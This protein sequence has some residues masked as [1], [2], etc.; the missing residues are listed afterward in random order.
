M[1]RPAL[2]AQVPVVRYDGLEIFGHILKHY[3]LEPIKSIDD[4]GKYPPEETVIVVFGDLTPLNAIKQA[5]PEVNDYV[6]L[7]ATDR[8]T[9]SFDVLPEIDFNIGWMPRSGVRVAGRK[10]LQE[11]QNAFKELT[12]CPMIRKETWEWDRKNV[13]HPLFARVNAIAT[14]RPSY[15]VNYRFDLRRL[16]PYPSDC[17]SEGLRLSPKLAN[18]GYVF[19]TEGIKPRTLLLAGHG[20]FMNGMLVAPECD[21]GLFAVN[22]VRWLREDPAGNRKYVL[23]LH[24][25]KVIDRLGLPLTGMPQIP[26]KLVNKL[27]RDLEDEGVF[28]RALENAVDGWSILRFAI[29]AGTALLVMYG[30]YRLFL[31]RHAQESVPL[32]VGMVAA[33]FAARPVLQERQLEL[34]SQDNLWEPAQALARQWFLDHAGVH[35]PVWDQAEAAPVPAPAYRVGWWKRQVLHKRLSE[36]WRFAVRDPAERVS[37]REFCRLTGLIAGLENARGAGEFAFPRAESR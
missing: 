17:W 4:L 31:T 16:A 27:L 19:V 2:R 33:P 15:V 13:D 28:H 25:G 11:E 5:V 22:V 1:D 9:D 34:L 6:F 23:F 32:V 26:I 10:V 30:M 20:V 18:W 21:N 12:S 3:K 29:L 36:L 8:E 7:L 24:D 37:L 35:A 14:N